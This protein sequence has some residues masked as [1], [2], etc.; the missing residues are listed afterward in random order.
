MNRFLILLV[1][2]AVIALP[3]CVH[4]KWRAHE[5]KAYYDSQQALAKARKPLFELKAQPGQVIMLTGVESLT[6]NDPR[7]QRIDA[8]PQ[9]RSP[10]WEL[11]GNVLRIGGQ[12]YGAKLAA[13]GV[14]NIVDH[15]TRNAGDH[16][17]TTITGSYNTQGDTLTNSIRGDV[18][19]AGAGIGN[20]Y[21]SADTTVTG[22]G[23]ATGVDAGRDVNVGDQNANTGRIHSNDDYS[24]DGN[25]CTGERCQ[26]NGDINPEA[27]DDGG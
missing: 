23:N 1:A 16:S 26:G 14:V 2:L 4:T 3:G 11:I 25:E 24:N 6:V 18:S 5:A 7:E 22:N 8:L 15:A 9:Q 20:T 13:D 12:I 19:G 27:D 17:V 10:A 21:S